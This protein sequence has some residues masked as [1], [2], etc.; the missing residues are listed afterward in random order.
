MAYLNYLFLRRRL[1]PLFLVLTVA[2]RTNL[3]VARGMLGR[4]GT[5]MAMSQASKSNALIGDELFSM[6]MIFPASWHS[7]ILIL[8]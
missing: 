2:W 3:V 6:R 4:G 8:S 1:K 7:E 5:L